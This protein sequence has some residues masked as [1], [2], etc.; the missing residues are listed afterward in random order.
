MSKPP[1][2]ASKARLQ[3]HLVEW[4]DAKGFGWIES[5]GERWFGHI[6]EF[7]HRHRRPARGDKVSFQRGQDARGRACARDIRRPDRR[8]RPG[9]WLLLGLL[10]ILP[11]SA[12][13]RLPLPL[14]VVPV[15]LLLAS[16]AAWSVY[17]LDK[18][19]AQAGAWR[20][21]EASLHLLELL[22]GWPGALL[23]QHHLRH[24]TRKVGFQI[25]FWSIV[26]FYQGLAVMIL[27]GRTNREQL[28]EWIQSV[29]P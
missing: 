13:L 20:I 11:L 7:R 27:I 22:G 15:W 28:L 21:S 26:A 24:K 1:S 25:L 18:R 19:R 29:G 14:W 9:C 16:V 3:G 23:A 2:E 6:K 12:T 10:L 8:I 17:A 4:N 5:G